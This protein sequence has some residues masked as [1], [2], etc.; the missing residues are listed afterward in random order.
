[1]CPLWAKS[2]VMG[3]GHVGKE[4]TLGACL[5]GVEF[6]RTC[7]FVEGSSRELLSYFGS[8]SLKIDPDVWVDPGSTLVLQQNPFHHRPFW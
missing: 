6:R 4:F 7:G 2:V 5:R 3:S 1:M 8:G